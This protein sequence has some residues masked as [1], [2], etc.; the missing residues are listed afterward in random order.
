[1][2][3]GLPQNDMASEQDVATA[4]LDEDAAPRT[5][6]EPDTAPD[7]AGETGGPA[8]AEADNPSAGPQ[9]TQVSGA[10]AESDE[11]RGA[12]DDL[13]SSEGKSQ[14]ARQIA[15]DLSR[16]TDPAVGEDTAG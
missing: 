5:G 13:R 14:E 1:V 9:L 8:V 7:A 4:S 2:T 6:L 11:M 12:T 3:S 10:A 16:R 15:G